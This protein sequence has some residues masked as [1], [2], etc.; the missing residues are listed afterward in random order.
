[1]SLIV[2]LDISERPPMI[3]K[4][5]IIRAG[6]EQN[7]EARNGVRGSRRSRMAGP[8]APLYRNAVTGGC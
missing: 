8:K 2:D 3:W 4:S 5:T 7:A 1:M 6:P